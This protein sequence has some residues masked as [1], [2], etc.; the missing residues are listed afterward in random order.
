MTQNTP[1]ITSRMFY[2]TAKYST[3]KIF[4]ALSSGI[5]SIFIVRLLGPNEYG[6]FALVINLAA[7]IGM[8]LTFGFIDT[9][10][11]FIVEYDNNLRKRLFSQAC[12]LTI[13]MASIFSII[14]IV[15]IE[16]FP[17]FF[18]IEIKEMKYIFIL[19][20]LFY[21]LFNIIQG[22]YRGIGK[23]LQWSII[24]GTQNFLGHI[25]AL[26]S[27]LVIFQSY[28]TMIK[29]I[30]FVILICVLVML[31]SLQKYIS[32][33][34]LKIES[35]II[36]FTL[37]L[38]IGNIIFM[39]WFIIDPVLLRAL[40]KDPS[41]VG[42]FMAGNR[43]PRL[44][45]TIILAPLQVPFLYYFSHPEILQ[46]TKENIIEFGTKTLGIILGMGSLFLFSFA[47]QIT[48]LLFSNA[49]IDAIPVLRIYSF[50][51]FLNA[52]HILFSPF[53]L[54]QNKPYIPILI[55]LSC[56][57]LITILNFF[58]IPVLKATGAA[59][60]TSI[61]LFITTSFSTIIMS[62]YN[63]KILINYIILVI[64]IILSVLA[65]V[66]L[67]YYLTPLVFTILIIATK[68]FWVD[69]FARIKKVIFT[70]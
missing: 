54:S 68:L 63:S 8:V 45:E 59:V 13:I 2:S 47:D 57:L 3:L 43:I 18:P 22:M 28:Q 32:L 33:I 7:A 14:L 12:E 30:S 67:N 36:R 1:S 51:L 34:N 19:L 10:S 48:I 44:I 17:G 53:F 29:S 6:K 55:S 42:I 15:G 41:H 39:F 11:K 37:T 64:C 61:S 20:T 24:D 31:F 58:L 23:F 46:E 5:V 49:Y 9:L 69:D 50:V 56:V 62:K 35:K 66:F 70:N 40:L 25:L 60:S 65:G 4:F 21:A 16:L 52:S 38:F 27:F 26:L